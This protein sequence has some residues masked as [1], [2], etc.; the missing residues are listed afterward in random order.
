MNEYL[1]VMNYKGIWQDTPVDVS[2]EGLKKISRIEI[3]VISGDHIVNIEYWDGR[4]ESYDS[5][6][7]CGNHRIMDFN[8]GTVVIYD[9][10]REI[11][12]V[13]EYLSTKGSYDVFELKWQKIEEKADD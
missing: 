12:F 13:K 1:K 5:A 10:M 6:E 9:E 3:E 7:L 4:D 2:D 11:N 8:D